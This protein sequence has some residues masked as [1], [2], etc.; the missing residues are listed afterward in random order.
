MTG[1]Q[2]DAAQMIDTAGQQIERECGMA[3]RQLGEHC[4]MCATGLLVHD[5]PGYLRCQNYTR[6]ADPCRYRCQD[7]DFAPVGCYDIHRIRP[8][9]PINTG[10]GYAA[11]DAE[12][13]GYILHALDIAA[14]MEED[15]QAAVA[16]LTAE[17][18][19]V[20]DALEVGGVNG[21]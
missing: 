11:R 4:P 3:V 1:G 21:T 12:L 17:L 7:A 8:A 18:G 13:Q 15:A 19:Y 14:R 9:A 16:Y 5:S 6:A 20:C 2:D 10:T